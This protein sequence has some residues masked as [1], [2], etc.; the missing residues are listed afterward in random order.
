VVAGV[1]GADAPRVD[2]R[3][4]AAAGSEAL[5]SIDEVPIAAGF[6]V[7]MVS[8]LTHVSHV[9]GTTNETPVPVYL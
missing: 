1:A 9:P 7:V 3:D 5:C 6:S 8:G 4:A 2:D